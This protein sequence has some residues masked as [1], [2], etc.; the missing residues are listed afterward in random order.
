MIY[1]LL[2]IGVVLNAF[3]SLFI[4]AGMNK[5]GA[6]SFDFSS[7]FYTSFKV[8]GNPFFLLGVLCYILSLGIWVL[9]L[10][11]MEVSVAYPMVSLGYVINALLAYI[12]LGEEFSLVR[13]AGILV[14]CIG[15][16]LV[17]RN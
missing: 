6:F 4:K 13:M 12:W 2:L 5:I 1:L 11:R 8:A 3:A 17:A 9:V 14:I 16:A 7:L 10:S 15:V